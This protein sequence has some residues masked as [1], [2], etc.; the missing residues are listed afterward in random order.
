MA[1]KDYGALI[2]ELA[3]GRLKDQAV[4]AKQAEQEKAARLAANREVIQ[5]VL[6]VLESA[7]ARYEDK[8]Y[9]FN[10]EYGTRHYY[11]HLPHVSA[12][13][14]YAAFPGGF[15]VEA[16]PASTIVLRNYN[17]NSGRVGDAFLAGTADAVIPEV[18]SMIA[19]MV[20]RR[21]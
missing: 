16:G 10:L 15:Q 13:D 19:D 14:P 11:D 9:V 2:A 5:P 21:P 17:G 1:Q 18:M 12:R 3:D 7:K 4:A 20:R 6:A 8:L